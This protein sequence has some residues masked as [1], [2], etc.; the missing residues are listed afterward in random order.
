LAPTRLEKL[1]PYSPAGSNVWELMWFY[2]DGIQNHNFT[3]SSPSHG[4]S[5]DRLSARRVGVRIV[6]HFK[7][8]RIAL[9]EKWDFRYSLLVDSPNAGYRPW[10]L[11]L[12]DPQPFATV[13]RTASASLATLTLQHA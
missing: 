3:T 6:R 1:I 4:P 12:F 7:S 11:L 2:V 8:L 5:D 13:R 9:S 10:L